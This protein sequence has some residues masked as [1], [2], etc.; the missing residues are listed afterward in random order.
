M[1]KNA[2]TIWIVSSEPVSTNYE[3]SN[4]TMNHFSFKEEVSVEKLKEFITEFT[5]NLQSAFED[6][7]VLEKKFSIE[8]I[9][10]SAA[11]AADGKLSILGTSVGGKVE[12]SIKFVFKRK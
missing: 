8:T 11:M 1:K 2:K 3:S 5:S 6:I 7:D 12:G 9:E 4:L 10:L